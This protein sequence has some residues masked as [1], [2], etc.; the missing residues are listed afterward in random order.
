[1]S[2]RVLKKLQGGDLELQ[3]NDDNEHP[4]DDELET[5]RDKKN[6]FFDLVSLREWVKKNVCLPFCKY[7]HM[8]YKNIEKKNNEFACGWVVD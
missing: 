2:S 6:N 4:S 3:Q 5:Q 1:M 7:I 8:Y